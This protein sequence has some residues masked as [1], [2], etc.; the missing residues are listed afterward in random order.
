M[1]KPGKIGRKEQTDGQD[2][3]MKNLSQMLINPFLTITLM[4]EWKPGPFQVYGQ[5]SMEHPISLTDKEN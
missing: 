1:G 4:E 3:V 5:E 2:I